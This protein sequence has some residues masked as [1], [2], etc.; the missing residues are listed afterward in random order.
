MSVTPTNASADEGASQISV[1]PTASISTQTNATLAPPILSG[2]WPKI[3]RPAMKAM[4]KGF[5]A[6]VSE[7]ARGMGLDQRIGAS[8]LR[9]GIGYG[10]S[11][12]APDETLLVR[13]RGWPRLVTFEQLWELAG[14]DE[15]AVGGE[16]IEPEDL[17]VWSWVPGEAEP[18]WMPASVLTKRDYDG[19][20]VEVRTEDR[21]AGSA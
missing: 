3:R 5:G 18:E 1:W 6:D 10:G 8:F 7:V 2:R 11:C 14:G 15:A 19:E 4:L 21:A 12:F 13:Y 16:A 9:A 17:H 20:L